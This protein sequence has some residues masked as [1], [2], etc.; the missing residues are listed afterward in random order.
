MG[1]QLELFEDIE[2]SPKQ[3]INIK[4]PNKYEECEWC[5]QFDDNQPQVFAWTDENMGDDEPQVQ[6]T[7]SNNEHSNITFTHKDGNVFKIFAREMT[8]EG[9][10]RQ[11]KEKL[12]TH[13]SKN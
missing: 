2:Y 13:E 12:F 11:Q 3:S 5:F 1:K 4:Q 10:E 7:I 8:E 9:K 6:F